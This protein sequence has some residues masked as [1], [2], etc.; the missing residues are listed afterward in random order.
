MGECALRAWTD[1][2]GYDWDHEFDVGCKITKTA[3]HPNGTRMRIE[4]PPLPLS[5]FTESGA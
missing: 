1:K 4:P 2:K 5:G 3:S